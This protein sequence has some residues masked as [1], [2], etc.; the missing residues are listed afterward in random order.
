MESPTW[1]ANC[2][3]SAFQIARLR[4]REHLHQWYNISESMV[5]SNLK[6]TIMV[7]IG[8]KEYCKLKNKFWNASKKNP[9]SALTRRLAA[10]VRVS[11]FVVHRTLKVQGLHHASFGPRWFS[12]SWNLLNGC[13]SNLMNARTFYC[14]LFTDES[15]FTRY[16]VFNSHNTYIRSSRSTISTT[17][18]HKCV[19]RYRKWPLNSTLCLPNTLNASYL[20]FFNNVLE[21]QVDVE[22]PLDERVR[23]RYLHDGAPPHFARPVTKWLNN[24]FPNQCVGR[25]GPVAWLLRSPDLNPCN[26][27]LWSRTKQLVIMEINKSFNNEWK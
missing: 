8:P 17:V 25:S 19:G 26:F 10:E 1:P 20:E 16:A 18:F 5:P 13:Y 15:G 9:T 11:Q 4:R 2:R 24:H 14:I 7:V 12:T 23:I 27:C 21:G 3:S 22:V 6:F